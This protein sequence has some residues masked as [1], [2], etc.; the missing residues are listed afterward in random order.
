MPQFRYLF[1]A[2]ALD[3]LAAQHVAWQAVLFVLDVASPTVQEHLGAAL[4]RVIGADAHGHL[5][6]V[7]LRETADDDVYE[8]LTARYLDADESAAASTLL[9]RKEER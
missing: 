9:T 5:L 2:G 8:I 6:M 7:T 4:L 1:S 3:R